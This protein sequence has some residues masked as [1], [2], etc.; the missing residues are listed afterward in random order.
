MISLLLKISLRAYHKPMPPYQI[1]TK[2]QPMMPLAP[3]MLDLK[4]P[5]DLENH[6]P[7]KIQSS[8]LN[9]IILKISP[10]RSRI[11]EINHFFMTL[12]SLSST[13]QSGFN[14]SLGALPSRWQSKSSRKLSKI[15]ISS[16]FGLI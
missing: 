14:N 3:T 7:G 15:W 5:K 11:S 1:L 16:K 2:E 8:T 10:K 13:L 12:A 4:L 9:L 6:T